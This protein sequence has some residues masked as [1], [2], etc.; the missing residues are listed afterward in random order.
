MGSEQGVTAAELDLG[1]RAASVP[2]PQPSNP[3]LPSHQD[4]RN[5]VQTPTIFSQ[6]YIFCLAARFQPRVARRDGSLLQTLQ[7]DTQGSVW[8]HRGPRCPAAP[9]ARTE[10]RSEAGRGRSKGRRDNFR[11]LHMSFPFRKHILFMFDCRGSGSVCCSRLRPEAHQKQP[12]KQPFPLSGEVGGWGADLFLTAVSAPAPTTRSS[13]ARRDAAEQI[14]R[15]TPSFPSSLGM[16]TFVW[17]SAG[18]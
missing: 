5:F 1:L 4:A 14:P 6:L 9:P 7:P 12:Q 15:D 16:K 17:S 3:Q 13:G 11:S 8:E 18:L 10:G 2:Q